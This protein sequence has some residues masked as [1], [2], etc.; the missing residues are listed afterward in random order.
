MLEAQGVEANYRI[1]VTTTDNGNPLCSA[2]TPEGGKLVMSSC[3]SR[4]GDFVSGDTIDVQDLACTDICTLSEAELTIQ[5][6]A[7]DLDPNL[8]AR[9]WLEKLEGRIRTSPA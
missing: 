4:L 6:T 3:M 8:V 5:P 1:G 9:P 2:S 7:T